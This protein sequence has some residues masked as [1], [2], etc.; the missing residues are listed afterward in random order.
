MNVTV[1]CAD[2]DEILP[3]Q[4]AHSSVE[5]PCPKCSSIRKK[6]QMEVADCVGIEVRGNMR[7]RL[8][9]PNFSSRKNLCVEVIAGDDLRKSDGRWMKKERVVDKERD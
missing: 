9:D 5:H 4:W 8:K 6:I 3:A 2:Y 1:S 7:A